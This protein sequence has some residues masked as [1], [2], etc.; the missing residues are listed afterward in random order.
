MNSS[1]KDSIGAYTANAAFFITVSFM[2]FIMLLISILRFLPLGETQLVQQVASIFPA[3]AKEIVA[4]VVAES[5]NKSDPTVISIT[6]IASLWA[7]SMGIHSLTKGIDRIYNSDKPK[8]IIRLR[9][10][11]M[12]YTL[13]VFAVI[14]FWLGIVVFGDNISALIV[15]KLPWTA[16]LMS[17]LGKLG[18]LWSF[19]ILFLFFILMYTVIPSK[20]HRMIIQVPGAAIGAVGCLGVSNL[21][22]YYYE[23]LLGFSSVYGGLTIIVF[24][25]FWLFFCLYSLFIGAEVNKCIGEN[26]ENDSIVEP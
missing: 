5:Y 22:A 2:P 3:A 10:K 8:S 12:I 6:A 20:K 13:A 17:I 21:F 16:G 15:R 9:F 1:K 11:S 14:I 26:F 4:T 7:A 18:G 25:M 19:L 24:F 23:A